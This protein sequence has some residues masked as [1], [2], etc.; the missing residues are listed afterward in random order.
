MVFLTPKRLAAIQAKMLASLL[1]VTA[2]KA[3]ASSIPSSLRTAISLPSALMMSA[4]LIF[5]LR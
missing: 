1:S 2:T 5:S 3:S 4:L